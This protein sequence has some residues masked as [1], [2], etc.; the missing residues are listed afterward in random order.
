MRYKFE[1][2]TGEETQIEILYKLLKLRSHN[3]SHSSM[4]SYDVHRTFVEN[5]PYLAWYIVKRDKSAIGSLYV[6]K[7]NSIGMNLEDPS[8]EM[9]SVCIEFIKSHHVAQSREASII[10]E[11]FY[12]NVAATNV[13]LI[14]IMKK[15]KLRPLQVSYEL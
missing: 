4:P 14:N 13:V 3:I 12:V 9:V 8:T 1:L 2:V 10:P 6:K 15:M 11:Y 5:N 7:D